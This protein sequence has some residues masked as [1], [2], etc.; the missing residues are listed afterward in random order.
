MIPLM[1]TR[2]TSRKTTRLPPD[3]SRGD[4]ATS[5]TR[6]D[7]SGS[8]AKSS[9]PQRAR[10]DFGLGKFLFTNVSPIKGHC[11]LRFWC[12]LGSLQGFQ[13]QHFP[14]FARFVSLRSGEPRA[15]RAAPSLACVEEI[16]TLYWDMTLQVQPFGDRVS[17]NDP[18][19]QP[20]RCIRGPTALLALVSEPWTA[21]YRTVGQQ[22]LVFALGR[23]RRR[24]RDTKLLLC[25][26]K[27][28]R[29]CYSYLPTGRRW[30]MRSVSPIGSLE[31]VS[32]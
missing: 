16:H 7:L 8:K 4:G 11:E 27:G 24:Q 10:R 3:A 31:D 19:H 14:Q 21:P 12:H 13:C 6:P 30:S 15:R 32:P 1:G 29:S 17:C 23:P 20:T 25:L 18:A 28:K 2:R 5:H 22:S 9:R 26:G